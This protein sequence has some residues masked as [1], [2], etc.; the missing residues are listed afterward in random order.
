MTQPRID[1]D[2]DAGKLMPNRVWL[3]DTATFD[4]TKQGELTYALCSYTGQNERRELHEC[5]LD[6]QHVTGYKCERLFLDLF[7]TKLADVI[8]VADD[9]EYVVSKEF[10]GRLEKSALSG[11]RVSST[12]I[13][14]DHDHSIGNR[15]GVPVIPE[16]VCLEING[17][18]R[19]D[20]KRLRIHGA[21]NKCPHCG[22]VAMV[23]PFCGETN[24]PTCANCDQRTLFIPNDRINSDANGFLIS[25]YPPEL[26]VVD[27]ETW[28]GADFFMA[29]GA[30]YVSNRAKQWFDKMG[31]APNVLRPALLNIEGMRSSFE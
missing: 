27:G 15:Y 25:G 3:L 4:A 23:C 10:A 18:A 29:D 16:L 1:F 17:K 19:G 5:P 7:G 8:I 13:V 6:K 12:I 11:Y 22:K 2:K 20:A 30:A 14:N 21:P 28:D 26:S 24:W 31:V 9:V